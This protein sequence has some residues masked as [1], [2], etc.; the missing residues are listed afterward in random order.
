MKQSIQAKQW[1]LVLGGELRDSEKTIPVRSPY[2][3]QT[4]AEIYLA[5]FETLKRSVD[6]A[7]EGFEKTRKL[8][9]FERS[10]ILLKIRDGIA[11][12]KKEFAELLC[13]EAGKPIKDATREIERSMLTFEVAAEEAKRVGGEFLDLSIA[14]LGKGRHGI[15]RPFPIGPILCITPFNFPLNLVAHKLAPAIAVGSS[16]ILKPASQTPLCAL[17][18]AEVILEAGYPPLA[19]NVLPCES[20]HIEP[21][22]QDERIKMLSFTG[23]P[24]VGWK[25]KAQAGKMK[26]ALELGGNAGVII[27]E[28]A[29]ITLAAQRCSVGAFSYAGQTCISVQRIYVHESVMRPFTDQLLTHIRKIKSGDPMDESTDLGPMIDENAAKRSETWIAEAVNQGAKL[30]N[31]G[32]RNGKFIEPTVLM[33]VTRDMKVTCEEVFAPLLT[34]SPFTDFREAIEAV[35]DSR[36]GLQA[37]VFTNRLDH[38]NEAYSELEVGGVLINEIPTWRI[39]SM[40]YGG[41]KDSGFGR[42]GVRYAMQEMSEGKL[43][44]F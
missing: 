41:I 20:K 22:M 4:V 36:Y 27:D 34:L 33:D 19:V 7:C 28:T 15:Y 40:P 13:L 42:E 2:D 44:V 29:D 6:L 3:D 32:K 10:E 26:V 24:V 31:G 5:S 8:E 39:E 11:K 21:L 17:K 25:L 43:L 9:A 35:N 18:L 23:S 12:R 30:L 1:K 16:F 14:P 37:G 38:V